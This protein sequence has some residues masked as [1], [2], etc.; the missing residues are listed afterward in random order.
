MFLI[1]FS[2]VS[3]KPFK[4]LINTKGYFIEYV[5]VFLKSMLLP[6]ELV[7]K[8]EGH[9]LVHVSKALRLSNMP[10]VSQVDELGLEI[11]EGLTV[12][13]LK[14]LVGVAGIL[15]FV[16]V[17]IYSIQGLEHLLVGG[18]GVSI[19]SV[20]SIPRK[21]VLL[22]LALRIAEDIRRVVSWGLK[23]R[24][25]LAELVTDKLLPRMVLD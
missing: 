16:G 21:Q 24:P 1:L 7:L 15:D 20:L 14:P 6:K 11:L 3:V 19:V 4:V 25:V 9:L 2:L 12:F 13:Y 17:L 5:K 22:G 8:R 10:L 18:V 23:K